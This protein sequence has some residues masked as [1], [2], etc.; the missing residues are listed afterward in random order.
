[1]LTLIS[2]LSFFRFAGLN[3]QQ[4]IDKAAGSEIRREK[5]DT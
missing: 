1:M 4:Q 5:G 3:L 2:F